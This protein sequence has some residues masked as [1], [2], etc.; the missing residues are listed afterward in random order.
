MIKNK[1]TA[2]AVIVLCLFYSGCKTTQK[3]ASAVELILNGKQ[4]EAKGRFQTKYDI[5]AVDAHGNTALHAAAQINDADL[6]TFLIIK[7]ADTDLKNY[8]SD[9]A[10]HVAIKNNSLDAAKVLA[11]VGS[12]LFDRNGSGRTALDLG[13][14]KNQAYYDIFITTKSGEIRNTDGESIVH[15]FV[16]TK[17][18]QAVLYCI[19]KGLPLS[20]ADN[21]GKTPLDA[22]FD[23]IA[24]ESSVEIA[25][26]L[27]MGGADHV[28][29]AF[30]YFQDAVSN[31]N[32]D[33]RFNDGQTPLHL[34]AS[35]GHSGIAKYLLENNADTHVQDITGA[36]P[37]HEAVR[38]GHTDI[39]KMLLDAGADINA[40]DNL[41]KTPILLIIPESAR[42]NMYRLLISYKADV[43]HKDTYGDTI[44][45]TATMTNLP[46][47]IL[48]MLA[49]AGADVNARNKDGVTPLS[50]AI[51]QNNTA[52]VKFYAEHGADINSEDKNGITPLSLALNGSEEMLEMI[53]NKT[54]IMSHD[55]AG[56]TPLHVAIISDA[57]LQKIQYILSLMD[58]VNARN[59]D[60]NS[61]LYLA[62]LKNR[63]KLGELLL[64]KNADIFSTNNKNYSPLY[65]ALKA[66]GSVQDWLIT[67]QTITATDGSGNT[68]LHYAAEWKLSNAVMSLL[69]KGANPAAK[70]ANGETPLFSAVKTNDPGMI[71]I[72]IKGGSSVQDRDHLGSTPLHVAV[73]WDADN[74]VKEL[75]RLGI[76]VNA[77]NISGKS[78]L[79]EAVLAGK[80]NMASL[81]IANGADTNSSD[82]TGR[83]ILMD[84]IRGQ[85]AD[86][87]ALL[88]S[89]RANPQIQEINGR[90]AY[91]EAALTGNTRVIAAIR[92]AGGN[93][94]SRDKNGS[95][96]FSLSLNQ[97]EQIIKAVLGSDMTITDSDGNT[98]VHII[99]QSK[100]P[101]KILTM[102]VSLGYP[103]DT[104]N[105]DG[106]TPLSYAVEK[107][108]ENYALI[109]LQNGANPFSSIDKKGRNAASI[110]LQKSGSRILADIVKYAGTKSDIQGN[111][112]LHYAARISSPETIQQLLSYGL[113]ANV[114]NISGETP[115]MTAIRW[116]RS[117]AASVLKPKAV[118]K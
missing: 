89:N 13:L 114:K 26:D 74:S 50:I 49:G 17:N 20:V 34:A 77:Q 116:K 102:L 97:N 58:N 93:P 65:L 109:L 14:E 42:S 95:T 24:D 45:H 91:H 63:Q 60:G 81:L 7:G 57:S 118:E 5:N 104:R 36:T 98:P 117:D 88:L 113:D 2:L 61:A 31:R 32:L 40:E 64:A 73:R 18:E 103:I 53:V 56:N 28:D 3:E 105:A 9:T 27:I 48:L 76:D 6:V 1:L 4:D 68:A 44:L 62:V 12:N 38:Y 79:A 115:Y 10:L 19:K 21:A 59:S 41:G 86:V 55:S 39:A 35:Q 47:D 107:G 85:N 16:K 11:T 83:T 67:S 70:N 106:C 99:V 112:I 15:Y 82:S 96:P 8:D 23:D 51:Q 52:H 72:M 78:A 66:G 29:S 101:E 87:I 110:A 71:D 100:G 37:L 108:Y 54:N 90:N 92:E 75:L 43:T 69:E 33:Y 94:L 25:A 111:T 22:A 84:A 30:S 46:D 80:L